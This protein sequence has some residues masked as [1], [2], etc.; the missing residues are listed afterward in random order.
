M[1][2]I[3]HRRRRFIFSFIA[4]VMGIAVAYSF[5]APRVFETSAK[6][7]VERQSDSQKAL[8]FKM[9][10]NPW[11]QDDWLTSEKEMITSYPV[12]VR[13]VKELN[14]SQTADEDSSQ[15]QNEPS[16]EFN[17]AVR[18]FG[19]NL[20]VYNPKNT[21]VMEIRFRAGEAA[22]SAAIVNKIIEVYVDYRSEVYNES[23]EYKFFE[24]QMRVA[25]EKLREL[26]QGLA[27]YKDQE[28]IVSPEMHSE[29]LHSKLL[30]YE[31]SLTIVRTKRIGKEAKLAV[32]KEK[33][34]SGMYI[35]IPST[36]ASEYYAQ[37]NYINQLKAELLDMEIRRDKLLLRYKPAYEEV[38]ELEQNIA[39]VKTKIKG[40]LEHIVDQEESIIEALRAE[41]LAL[42]RSVE[43]I[44][45]DIQSFSQREYEFNQLNRGIDDNR[46]IYS[47]L[48][49]QREEARISL[50]KLERDAKIRVISPPVVP[51][52][53]VAPQKAVILFLA[54]MFGFSAAI[55][56]AFILEYFNHSI[57]SIE[58]LQQY[59][60]VKVLGA[61]RDIELVEAKVV[62]D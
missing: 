34:N 21:N 39:S 33:M 16:V 58:E 40:E 35:N 27:D 3:L 2:I 32:I 4:V 60:G 37:E 28:K 22:Q 54:M 51:L 12:A 49:K 10:L 47:I 6:I 44:N 15:I 61:V 25:D 7:V 62:K 55:G 26:E 29:I 9:N 53:P 18:E 31:K 5:L 20:E 43:Q 57:H 52:K 46:E 11:L 17:A 36:E 38:V 42:Q 41:E 14:L 48:L 23:E 30:D 19:K 24:E 50:S 56:I 45:R 8:L 59:S 1:V 13:V